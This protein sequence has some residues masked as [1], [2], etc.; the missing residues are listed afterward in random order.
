MSATGRLPGDAARPPRVGGPRA[1][2]PVLEVLDEAP[3][4]PREVLALCTFAAA[5]CASTR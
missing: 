2:K 3:L 4:L 1:Y 5:K